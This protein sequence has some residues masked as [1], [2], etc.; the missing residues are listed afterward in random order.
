MRSRFSR[1]A[2][3]DIAEIG[4]FI[5][6]ENVAR[7][8]TFVQELHARCQQLVAFPEAAPSR[9]E[10]GDGVRIAVFGHYVILS[11]VRSKVG[12]IRRVVHGARDLAGE[13]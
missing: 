5:A 9:P 11:V 3:I 12:E 10:P 4:G 2:E 8:V 1:R 13:F 7:A 6:R